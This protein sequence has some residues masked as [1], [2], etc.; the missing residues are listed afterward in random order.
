MSS[1]HG[2]VE[3][4]TSAP[5]Q[6]ARRWRSGVSDKRGPEEVDHSSMMSAL[7]LEKVENVPRKASTA[8]TVPPDIALMDAEDLRKEKYNMKEQVEA[9]TMAIL[10]RKKDEYDLQ[11]F[12]RDVDEK[13]E[14]VIKNLNESCKHIHMCSHA[15]GM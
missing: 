8:E 2:S 7:S 3:R 5:A 11:S 10:A 13:R 4:A 15:F 14:A 12:I 9:A 6:T 1:T